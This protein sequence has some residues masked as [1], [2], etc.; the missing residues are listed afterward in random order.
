MNSHVLLLLGVTAVWGTTFPLLKSLLVSLSGVEISA[1]RFVIAT[2]CVAPFLRRVPRHTWL[3]GLLLGALALLS[4]VAQAYGLEFISS[5]RSAFLTSLNVL[6]VPLI[7]AVLGAR[8]SPRVLLCAVLACVGIGLMSWE[9]GANLKGDLATLVCALAYAFYT[10]S[11]SGRAARH[12]LRQLAA[13]QIAFMALLACA[14]LIGATLIEAKPS[15]LLARAAPHWATLAYL[16]VFAT[17]V[18]L[19]LQALGQRRV[20][21]DKAALVFAMEPVFAALAAWLWVGEMLS[22]RAALGGALVLTAVILSEL[23]P[24]RL[25]LLFTENVP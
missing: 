12:D 15:N 2:L 13:T 1:L 23:Q 7:G 3:D 18:M 14:W 11:L 9:G 20:S 22:S 16:G 8:L 6:M 4:Y 17:A 24:G 5:N 25:K 10:I 21:A 19:F